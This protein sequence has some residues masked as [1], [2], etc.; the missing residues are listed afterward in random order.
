MAY[1]LREEVQADVIKSSL[2]AL[3]D[4]IYI[5]MN[6]YKDYIRRSLGLTEAQFIPASL[7]EKD[8]VD[9]DELEKG[10]GEEAGEHGMPPKKARQTAKDHLGEPN[11]GHYYTGMEKAKKSGMLKDQMQISPTARPTPIIALGIRGSSSGGLPSGADQGRTDISPSKVGGYDRVQ[12]QD[13]NHHTFDKTPS[14]PEIKQTNPVNP[15]PST[16]QAVTH[17]HQIQV[18]AHE[19]PQALTGASTDSD[20]TLKL[21]SAVPKGIDIDIAETDSEE[22]TKNEDNNTAMIPST[23]L[24]ETFNR[25]KELMEAKLGLKKCPCSQG[26]CKCGPNCKCKKTGVCECATCGCGDPAKVHDEEEEEVKTDTMVE[27]KSCRNHFNYRLVSEIAMGAVKCPACDATLDQNGMVLSE[28]KHKAGCECGFCKNMGSFGKKKKVEEDGGGDDPDFKEK[29]E[30]QWRKDRSA[31]KAGDD[32]RAEFDKHKKAGNKGIGTGDDDVGYDTADYS[33]TKDKT[34]E[35]QQRLDESYAAP[36][37]R[38]RSLAGVGNMI[39]TSN[40]LMENKNDPGA[41]KPFNTNW[42][43]DKEKAGFVKIDEEKL[44]KIKASLERKSK[45]GTLSDDELELAK[46][47]TEV[48]KRRQLKENDDVAKGEHQND[49]WAADKLYAKM[50]KDTNLKPFP[51]DKDHTG[52]M[53]HGNEK[54]QLSVNESKQHTWGKD[55]FCVYCHNVHRTDSNARSTCSDGFRC[56]KDE[57]PPKKK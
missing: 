21:K 14:N 44:N 24:S 41:N 17:P 8:E 12:S 22:E 25:H 3:G 52:P 28:G 29:D 1:V 5:H 9:P 45:R 50:Q 26:E 57:E 6:D 19:E 27:C 42:K 35:E 38:M 7:L 30:K 49:P 23:S 54:G 16:G 37:Q 39:L 4:D 40:G 13:L 18:T 32:V 10:T 53:R 15:D 55:G 11:Q 47:L 51:F 56:R 20:D 43:M 34:V 31:S 33:G 46:K 2:L 48:L 36:F